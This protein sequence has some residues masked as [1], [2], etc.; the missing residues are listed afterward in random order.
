MSLDGFIA[1]QENDL[2]F[3]SE[4]EQEGQ[5]YGYGEF[6]Q[7]V[8]TVIIGRKTY[9]QVLSMGFDYPHTDKEV[10]IVTRTPRNSIGSFHFYTDK[11]PALI[12]ALKQ[13][14]GK[15]IYCDGGAEI[16]NELQRHHLIDEYI[17]SLIP[18]LLGDGIRLFKGNQLEQKLQ[19][20]N[21]KSF[22]KG[23]IQLHYKTRG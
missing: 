3:L 20:I 2:S 22:E 19:L 18:V 12:A 10:Y 9:D 7:E 16:V 6:I 17:I 1:T 13:K 23:L 5:D 4:M 11:L 21:S 15:H 8:D 14:P